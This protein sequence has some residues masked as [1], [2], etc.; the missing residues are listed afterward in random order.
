MTKQQA[1]VPRRVSTTADR[2][3]R[4]Q[5][6]SHENFLLAERQIRSKAFVYKS[7]GG[8]S[9]PP[10]RWSHGMTRYLISFGAHAMDHIPDKEMPAVAKASHEVVQEAINA[11]SPSR[12]S[13]RP[14]GSPTCSS[15][16]CSP[17]PGNRRT[18]VTSRWW[19]CSACS[20]C[21]SSKPP[22][23]LPPTSAKNTATGV[24]RVCGKGT[25]VVLVPLPPAVGRAI[26]QA[27]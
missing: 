19:P 11:G 16:R 4:A 6:R 14:G 1:T 9:R 3:A 26:D 13:H 5:Q 25:K 2:R 27:T 12:R 15:R 23:P 21:E 24:L 20:A 7:T 8:R 18:R 10:G 17:P 22:G